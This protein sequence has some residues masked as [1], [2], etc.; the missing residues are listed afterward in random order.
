M[1]SCS[2]ASR[3][4]ARRIGFV[5]TKIFSKYIVSPV[6]EPDITGTMKPHPPHRSSRMTDEEF[7]EAHAILMQSVGLANKH[8]ETLLD[9]A[10]GRTAVASTAAA[11][12]LSSYCAAAGMSMHDAIGLFMFIHKETIKMMKEDEK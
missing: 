1:M 3:L 7:K 12:M 5:L 8:G 4:A 2:P 10:Q 11:I 9:E 6:D